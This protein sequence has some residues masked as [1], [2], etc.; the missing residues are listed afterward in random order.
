MGKKKKHMKRNRITEFR[1]YKSVKR[2]TFPL[3][4]KTCKDYICSLIRFCE[5]CRMDP[6]QLVSKRHK[7]LESKDIAVKRRIEDLVMDYFTRYSKTRSYTTARHD[8]LCLKSFFKANGA[9]LEIRNPR[10]SRVK[11]LF[12]P[13]AKDIKKMLNVSNDLVKL[14]IL[15]MFQSGII[16]GTL[17]KLRYRHVK[18]DLEAGKIPLC[19]Y[20]STYEAK[21]TQLYCTFLGKEA[22]EALRNHIKLRETGTNKVKPETIT[23][24]SP[25]IKRMS[26]SKPIST[27]MVYKTV[28]RAAQRAGLESI[29]PYALRRAFACAL[30]KAG[31][32]LRHFECLM[33]H[34]PH[35]NQWEPHT[36]T[37]ERLKKTY[38]EALRYLSIG[39]V[40]DDTDQEVS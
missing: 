1:E 13:T 25:L 27:T 31:A 16:T 11:K 26:K 38:Q 35:W 21:G 36:P 30:M 17:V 19:I 32:P 12:I 22:C 5:W 4:Q 15:I 6:D 24:G 10:Y 2:W 3:S 28:R 34:T 33:G 7:N 39:P 29:S 40:T 18:E 8:V 14:I 9:P 23:N 37:K 20:L